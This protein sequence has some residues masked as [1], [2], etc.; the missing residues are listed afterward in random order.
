MVTEFKVS[1]LISLRLEDSKTILYIKNKEFKQCKIL[2]LNIP[3][4]E[5]EQ[6]QE[7]KSINEAAERLDFAMEQKNHDFVEPEIEFWGHCSN[8]QAWVENN[9]DTDLLHTS[10]SFPLLKALSEEGDKVAM[11]RFKEEIARRYKYGNYTIQAYLFEEGY[12]SYLSR[13]DILNGVLSLDEANF[14]EKV[15]NFR[16]NYFLI[17]RV[18]LIRD[19]QRENRIFISVENGNIKELELEIDRELS[20]IPKEIKDLK[21]LNWLTIYI[22]NSCENLYEESFTLKSVTDLVIGCSAFN[23]SIP[24]LFFYFP[25]LVNLKIYGIHCR[26]DVKLENSFTNLNRL[27]NLNLDHVRIK[28]LPDTITELKNLQSLTIRNTS[29]MSLPTSIFESIKSLKALNLIHN[30]ELQISRQKIKELEKKA[31]IFNYF[32]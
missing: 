5:I 9:F 24:D 4:S 16:R 20:K 32:S 6:T 22:R 15:W 13:D 29:L 30:H 31:K 2:L 11:Q 12:L 23:I 7:I 17:P 1:N 18:D 21:Y 10:L 19:I 14:I 28:K 27:E 25:N 3:T 8:L 26:P